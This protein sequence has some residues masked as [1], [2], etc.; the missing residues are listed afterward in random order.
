MLDKVPNIGEFFLADKGYDSDEFRGKIA[1]RNSEP[2]IPGRKNR[3]VKI[4]YD[5]EVY[6]ARHLVENAFC[7]LKQFRAVAT[8]YDKLA[9]NFMGMVTMASIMIWARL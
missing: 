3:K 8:R 4:E 9:R 5:R 2:V 1:E 7:N 6:G